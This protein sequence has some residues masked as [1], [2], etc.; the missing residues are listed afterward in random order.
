[1]GHKREEDLKFSCDIRENLSG[2]MQGK[3]ALNGG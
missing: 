1:M 3:V 2:E